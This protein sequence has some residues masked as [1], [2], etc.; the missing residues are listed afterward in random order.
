[1][2]PGEDISRL[3]P[4]NVRS[5]LE[6]LKKTPIDYLKWLYGNLRDEIYQGDILKKIVVYTLNDDGIVS[7]R[8]G[9]A[10]VVSPTCDCQPNQSEFVLVAPVY[11]FS[12]L[13]P[14][15]DF[16]EA[17]IANFKQDLSA[18]R[19]K[20][21]VFLPAVANL[22]DSW[23]DLS[24]MFSIASRCFHSDAFTASR[25]RLISLSQKGHYFFLMRLGFFMGRPDPIDSKRS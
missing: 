25:E 15:E 3:I 12:E 18:N 8:E 22:P 24:Q 1:M 16:T 10:I 20:D 14:E 4:E 5:V 13:V 7:P 17:D 21:Q 9:S 23:L 19:L 6:D 2:F 11:S